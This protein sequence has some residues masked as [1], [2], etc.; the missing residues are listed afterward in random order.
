MKPYRSML[1]VPGQKPDWVR[2][3]FA[4]GA[5]AVILDLEDSVP[6]DLKD[7]ARAAV[8][9]ALRMKSTAGE[10]CD[11]WVRPNSLLSGLLGADLEEVVGQGLTGLLLPKVFTALDIVRIDAI[12]SHLE[13]RSRLEAGSIPLVVCLETAS[14]IVRCQEIAE[15]VPRVH[16]LLGTTG[17]DADVGREVGFEFTATGEE[18]LYLRSRIVLS[19][20][21]AGLHHP[22]CGVWQDIG[23][24]DGLR[25]FAEDNR[26]LG[27]RGMVVIHPTHVPIANEIFTPSQAKLA[28]YREMV[29]AFRVAEADG[30]AAIDFHGQHVD[31][32][33]IKTA[34]EVID[35]AEAIARI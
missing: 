33:H 11:L 15:A 3:G 6:A 23:D 24:H 20:R 21:A 13:Q 28:F 7:S 17:P 19:C 4:A 12:V 1:F 14:S 34:Q 29:A 18:T 5:D 10:R 27:Y 32:A 16:S 9:H 25:V 26:R 2:K 8:A 35:L 30:R 31:T 22:L